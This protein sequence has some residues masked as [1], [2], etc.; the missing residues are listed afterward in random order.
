MLMFHAAITLS[1]SDLAC[2][3]KFDWRAQD[4]H[5]ASARGGDYR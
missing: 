4:S 3:R 2:A 5:L 1:T